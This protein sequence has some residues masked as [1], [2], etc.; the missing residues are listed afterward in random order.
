MV[1]VFALVLYIGVGSSRTLTSEDI[2]FYRLDH[3]NYYA[4][5]IVRRYGYPD[6]QDYGTAY[7][8][9]KVVDSA[10]VTIYD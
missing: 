6:I 8:V 4:R 9:P 2:Y 7:C 5:E 3:C 1:H 10:K